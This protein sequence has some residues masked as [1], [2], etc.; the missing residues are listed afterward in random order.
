[1]RAGEELFA[2]PLPTVE[3]V[4]R[5]PRSEVLRHLAEET[6]G[7]DYGGQKYR[8]QH[9]A[10]FVGGT[11]SSMPEHDVAVPMILVR[12]GEHSTAIVTD[13][14][15]G[16]REIVVKTVG[17]Q[18]PGSAAF[19]AQRSSATGASASSSTSARWYA[20]SG[21]TAPP[22]APA[23]AAGTAGRPA[24]LRAGRRRFHHRAPR[25][26]APAG[27]ERHARRDGE[28]W[29]RGGFGAAGRGAGRD[30]ARHRDAA[31]GWLRSRFA[32]AQ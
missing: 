9:L 18:I 27:E 31:H 4:V 22:P 6:A 11:P 24:H 30:P 14:L 15:I 17:P 5:V 26:P 25:D 19:P 28:G 3:G 7:F 16:S 8:F 21:A 2:L 13:E 32:R 1:M 23:C 12:A 10:S 20:P 29:P